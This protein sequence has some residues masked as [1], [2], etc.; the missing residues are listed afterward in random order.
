MF[1]GRQLRRD[2]LLSAGLALLVIGLCAAV[3]LVWNSRPRLFTDIGEEPAIASDTDATRAATRA[4]E[5][6]RGVW[7]GRDPDRVA[8]E[9]ELS[10]LARA[11]TSS[12]DALGFTLRGTIYST[13]GE[14]L[15]FIECGGT[16]GVYGVGEIIEGWRLTAIRIS[17]V[18]VTRDDQERTLAVQYRPFSGRTPSALASRASTNDRVSEPESSTSV[19]SA[20]P[21]AGKGSRHGVATQG[22]RTTQSSGPVATTPRPRPQ[23]AD[24]TV[25]VAPELVERLRQDPTSVRF[26]VDFSPLVDK[27]GTMRGISVDGVASGSIAARYGL[28]PGD[29]ILAVNGQ[30]ISSPASAVQLYQ[31]YRNS[32]SVSVTLLRDGT[33]RN[34]VFYAR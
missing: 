19:G 28:A 26:G 13:T 20:R 29:R 27:R 10:D 5:D 12:S 4:A 23:G 3:Y 16:L 9:T 15:A 34:V 2:R 6:F 8:T 17:S 24:A 11:G 1:A 7:E 22:V 21:V 30:P 14:S 32:N 25:A 33:E 31:R 18:T